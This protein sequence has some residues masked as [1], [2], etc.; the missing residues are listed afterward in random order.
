VGGVR[1]RPTAGKQ[2][3]ACVA[4]R[5]RT[6]ESI[7]VHGTSAAFAGCRESVGLGRFGRFAAELVP[8]RSPH[9]RQRMLSGR[10]G[11]ERRQRTQ[12][13]RTRQNRRS[14]GASLLED[15]SFAQSRGPC[16]SPFFGRRHARYRGRANPRKWEEPAPGS[17]ETDECAARRVSPD[18]SSRGNPKEQVA[19]CHVR[20]GGRSRPSIPARKRESGSHVRTS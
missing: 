17:S 19:A 6:V 20:K 11:G 3:K 18:H 14:Q 10:R 8:C 1:E 2:A 7:Q 4:R 5:L 12:S 9:R 16:T 13:A 15:T